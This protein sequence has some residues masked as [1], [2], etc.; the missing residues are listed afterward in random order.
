MDKYF[1]KMLSLEKIKCPSCGTEMTL[2]V[3]D[4]RRSEQ[5]L[6]KIN[7]VENYL[8][9]N[10][11]SFEDM[12]LMLAHPMTHECEL[13]KENYDEDELNTYGFFATINDDGEEEMHES[14]DEYVFMYLDDE[15]FSGD[16]IQ[17]L[18]QSFTEYL[19]SIIGGEP[20]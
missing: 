16:I 4:A 14:E 2:V 20:Q 12:Y 7:N 8:S 1:E 3:C 6:I 10:P 9:A 11:Y 13:C 17:N 5:V 18:E 19:E 15:L